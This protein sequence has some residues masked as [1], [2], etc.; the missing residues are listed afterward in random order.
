MILSDRTLSILKNFAAI[1]SGVVLKKGTTQKTISPE[2]TI[3]VEA[4]IDEDL[5]ADFGVYDLNQFLGNITTLT[6]T[7][8]TLGSESARLSDGQI[9]LTY[10]ACKPNLIVTPPEKPLS[11]SKVDGKFSLSNATFQKIMKLAAMNNLPNLSV[12]GQ[13]GKLM[14][15]IHEKAN[16]TTNHGV[17]VLGDH[18]GANF[19]VTFKRENLKLIADDYDVE[20]AVGGFATFTTK[21]KKL[22]Y[23]IALEAK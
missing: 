3:F 1:N 4:E 20:F 9:E 15:K 19:E 14:L 23:A 10:H 7:D 21:D 17:T 18:E 22:R 11:L 8:I 16:D 6:N 5:S 2:K 12:V 13:D